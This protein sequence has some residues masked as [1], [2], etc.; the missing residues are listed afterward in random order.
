MFGIKVRKMGVDRP[1]IVHL[2]PLG[3]QL[4]C[5]EGMND[6]DEESNGD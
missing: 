6:R 4:A 3:I 2:A 5:H 1:G